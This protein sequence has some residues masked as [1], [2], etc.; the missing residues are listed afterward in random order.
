MADAAGSR[1]FPDGFI[2]GAATAG[3]QI[4]G[5]NVNT[6]L[7][8][9]ENIEPTTFV[10]RSGDACDSYH[11]YD[12]DIVLLARLGLSCYRFSIEWARIEPTPGEFSVAELDYYK[13]VIECCHSHG[14][15]PAVTF[16]HCAAPRWFA[17]A[18]G[19]LNPE[20][21]ALFARFC[22]TASKALA[23]GMAF[24]FTLNEPQLRQVFGSIPGAEAYFSRQDPL[25]LQVHANA[26]ALLGSDQ[27]V[28]T[29]HPNY[30]G[31]TAQLIGAHEQG[32]AAI[33]AE[34]GDLPVGVTLSVTDFQA[35]GDGSPVE[36]V[37]NKAYGAW[38]EVISR[39]GDFTG[40][41][42]YRSI[43]LPGT[44][45]DYPALPVLPFS[46]PNDRL[47]AIQRPEALGNTVEYIHSV[48]NKPVF[49]TENGLETENDER[50]VWHLTET[51]IGLQ[52]AIA[53]GVPVMGYLHWSLL[54]NFEWTR[55][56]APKMGIVAV[57]R[58]TF[59]RTAKP[60]AAHLGSIARRNAI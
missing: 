52:A 15:A 38:A 40:V 24:A 6:D 25:S 31:M 49:V 50:R 27:F 14:V 10:D 48:T 57:D 17:M 18:G 28:T 11:R 51:L 53:R 59:V 56:Y 20:A 4:E 45:P 60:S 42:T 35:G 8:F 1:A 2:W 9:L 32:Y 46:D 12:E 33:K 47:A 13:R 30:E 7:W 23:D 37:R 26:A 16:N 21:P 43:R 44:G 55:G 39:T 54:D 5:N 29:D 58:T 41:Q 19:W 36:E 3:H 22:A 34:R